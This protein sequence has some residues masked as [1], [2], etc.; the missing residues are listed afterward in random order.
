M[1]PARAGGD[2]AT[3]G[4]RE[5]A[6]PDEE[7]LG[8]HLDGLRFLSH[9]DRESGARSLTRSVGATVILRNGELIAYLRRNNPNIL[10][11]LSPEEPERMQP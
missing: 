11:F 8:H 3:R 9:R 7:R 6:V 10:T 1:F 5:E 4:P 2:P